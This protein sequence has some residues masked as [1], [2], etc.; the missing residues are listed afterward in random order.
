MRVFFNLFRCL[1][2]NIYRKEKKDGTGDVIIDVHSWRDSEGD[3]RSEALGFLRI[4]NPKEIENKLKK[5]SEKK[6]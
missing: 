6:H 2:F 4:S 3:R 1:N 5:L